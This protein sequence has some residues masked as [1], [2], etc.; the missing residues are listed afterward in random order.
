[1]HTIFPT[2]RQIVTCVFLLLATTS[3]WATPPT[4]SSHLKEAFQRDVERIKQG[5]NDPQVFKSE[6]EI[7]A[8]EGDPI[9]QFLFGVQIMRDRHQEALVW[10]RKAAKAGCAGAS[11]VVGGALL[12]ENNPE[13]LTWLQQA[14]DGGD[15]NAMMMI[16]KLYES[17]MMK[18]K[19][20][21]PYAVAW[22]ELAAQQSYSRGLSFAL[23]GFID[24]LSKRLSTEE[25]SEYR[26]MKLSLTEKHPMVPFYLC[27]QS[28][29]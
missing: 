10:L 19:R 14:A 1:M 22:A 26:K 13:G 21:L 23:P 28:L 9:A 25:K 15:A 8:Q 2:P 11:G 27:G 18:H 3:V 29:P 20:S 4:P 24:E 5:I 12:A 16:A 6:I 7:I 17:G